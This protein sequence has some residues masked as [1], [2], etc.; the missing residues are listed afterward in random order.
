MRGGGTSV[1]LFSANTI[2]PFNPPVLERID[3]L[4]FSLCA[5]CASV[6]IFHLLKY[7]NRPTLRIP[8]SPTFHLQPL[9]KFGSH[10]S[11]LIYFL[12]SGLSLLSRIDAS[13]A[14]APVPV[15]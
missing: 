13:R 1:P 14:A 5:L 8:E 7:H 11:P 6:A 9:Q 3:I 10:R 15:L 12:C 4:I 2:A